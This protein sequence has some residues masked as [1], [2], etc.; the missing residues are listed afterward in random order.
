MA[1]LFFNVNR[2]ARDT[3]NN[4]LHNEKTPQQT[5]KVKETIG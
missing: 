3:D 2:A 1:S 5:K 4:K